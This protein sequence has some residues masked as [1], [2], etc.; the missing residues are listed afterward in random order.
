MPRKLAR[1][2]DA[3]LRLPPVLFALLIETLTLAALVAGVTLT[4]AAYRIAA[5][6]WRLFQ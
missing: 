4:L 6:G 2:L 5:I 3:G 1:F